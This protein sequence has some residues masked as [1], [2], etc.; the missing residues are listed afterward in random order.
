[1]ATPPPVKFHVTFVEDVVLE[2]SPATH[3]SASKP[4]VPALLER[5]AMIG[6]LLQTIVPP[7]TMEVIWST[8]VEVLTSIN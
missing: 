1:L 4:C 6:E 8:P 2:Q 7:R 5:A 3:T